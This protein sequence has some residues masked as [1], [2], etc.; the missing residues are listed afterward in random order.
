MITK[1]F[2]ENRI[3]HRHNFLLFCDTE[4]ANCFQE[5][6]E[7]KGKMENNMKNALAYD[8]GGMVVDTKGRIY[9]KFSIVNSDIFF[10]QPDLM[11]SAYYAKKLPQYHA[12]IENGSRTVMNFWEMRAYINE[13]FEAYNIKIVCAH[14]ARFDKNTL[15]VTARFCSRSMVRYFFPYGTEW[16]DTLKMARSVMHKMPT[17]RKFCEANNYITKNG[18]LS[19]TAENLYR[20]ITKDNNFVENHTGLEDVEI[21][22]E[23]FKYC[24]RQHKAMKRNL[25]NDSRPL[26]ENTNFQIELM[27]N[28]KI[29]PTL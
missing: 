18:Q 25:Y 24:A 9:E 21:E 11:E 26:V 15:D 8:L 29:F 6:N 1:N 4:T 2:K 7:E 22:V 16:W 19:A 28:L 27:R 10:G 13:L 17:Y 12:G 14:N 3:D 23:I 5:W 20:F